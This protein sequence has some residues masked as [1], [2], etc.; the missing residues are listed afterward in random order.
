MGRQA[1]EEKYVCGGLTEINTL[2]GRSG[3]ALFLMW[4]ANMS[5]KEFD[6]L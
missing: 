3:Q 6:L 5:G 1:G 4:I 2:T